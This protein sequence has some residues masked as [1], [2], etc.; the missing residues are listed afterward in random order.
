[1]KMVFGAGRGTLPPVADEIAGFAGAHVGHG[2][3]R[4]CAC[5]KGC[6]KYSC[7]ATTRHWLVAP[8]RET[9]ELVLRTLAHVGVEP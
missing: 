3:L 1:M 2:R 4:D 8:N 7:R 5:G 6:R 9:A